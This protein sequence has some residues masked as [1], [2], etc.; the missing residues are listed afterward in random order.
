MGIHPPQTRSVE[1]GDI[2]A[3]TAEILKP[4]LL[5]R[6][7]SLGFWLLKLIRL[8]R[9]LDVHVENRISEIAN[10]LEGFSSGYIGGLFADYCVYRVEIH[11]P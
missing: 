6:N 4:G 11:I 2:R 9:K 3:A 10:R 8:L 1:V 5:M 7:L